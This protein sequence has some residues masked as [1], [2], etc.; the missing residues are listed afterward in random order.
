MQD[1]EILNQIKSR[2]RIGLARQLARKLL[3]E[4]GV[5]DAPVSMQKIGEYMEQKYNLQLQGLK[6][7]FSDKV[8]G[9]T[10]MID[11]SP[12]IGFNKDQSWYRRRFTIAHEIGHFILNT[13]H[14]KQ[15][16]ES[17]DL[18]MLDTANPIEKEANAFAA[19]LLM[20]LQQF[21]KD[22]R[23]RLRSLDDLSKKYQVSKEAAGWQL[24]RS[25]ALVKL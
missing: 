4:A 6:N 10:V 5:N 3:K 20:P 15:S 9:L 7:F 1:E 16:G 24:S 22:Y 19:E 17:G 25:G 14:Y 23:R 13:A 8:S 11:E 2:P 18:Q 12:T 21:K